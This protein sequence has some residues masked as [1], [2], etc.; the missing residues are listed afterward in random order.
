MESSKEHFDTLNI[1]IIITN[2]ALN[3]IYSLFGVTMDIVINK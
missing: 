1:L 3:F 2:C